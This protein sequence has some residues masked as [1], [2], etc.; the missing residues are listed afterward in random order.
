MCSS[1][2]AEVAGQSH[3]CSRATGNGRADHKGEL[4][5]RVMPQGSEKKQLH[6]GLAGCEKAGKFCVM[7]VLVFRGSTRCCVQRRV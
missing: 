3:N 7:F 5:V 2:L 6:A 4:I 1:S